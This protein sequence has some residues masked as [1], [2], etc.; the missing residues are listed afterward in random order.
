MPL[1]NGL[2]HFPGIE[3]GE[4]IQGKITNS[5]CSGLVTLVDFWDYTCLN[6]LRALP[7]LREWHERYAHLGLLVV[8]VHTPEFDFA[9]EKKNVLAAVHA[10]DIPYAVT[11]DNARKIW[12]SFANRVWPAKYLFDAEGRLR[13]SHLGEGDYPGF[14]EAIQVLLQK[15][16]DGGEFSGVMAPVRDSDRPGEVGRRGTPELYLGTDRSRIGNREQASG[17]G[18]EWIFPMP[19]QFLPDTVYLVG[20]W[21]TQPQFSRFVGEEEG[22]VLLQYSA[23]EVNLVMRSRFGSRLYILQD[24]RPLPAEFA[25]E[26]VRYE[27]GHAIV[28]VREP[29]LY[30]LIRSAEFG[31]HLLSF[32]TADRGLQIYALTF[33]SRTAPP[34][35]K[36]TD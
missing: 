16:N 23:A 12:D 17:E 15:R 6:C 32:S 26:D 30:Q 14:E 10:Y 22:H 29:R 19:S 31:S 35:E 11:L 21:S 1:E 20:K 13:Y 27:A 18:S 5:D 33:V 36:Q 2:I 9:R 28:D 4:W 24:A 3:G 25:G 34:D 8:G 7:Y